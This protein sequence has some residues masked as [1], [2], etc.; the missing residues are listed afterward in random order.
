MRGRRR[1]LRLSE[2][3]ASV[4][5]E[6][7]GRLVHDSGRVSWRGLYGKEILGSDLFYQSASP[8][9]LIIRT[10][11]VAIFFNFRRLRHVE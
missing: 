5:L 4:T 8:D 11:L 2:R 6:V 7:P 10:L 9:F 3:L 1:R